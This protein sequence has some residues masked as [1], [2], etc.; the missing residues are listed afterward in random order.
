MQLICTYYKDTRCLPM[1]VAYIYMEV[2][3]EKN[4]DGNGKE[5]YRNC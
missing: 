1:L 2:T 3:N 4:I 5:S